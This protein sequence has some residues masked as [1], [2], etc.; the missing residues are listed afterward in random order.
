MHVRLLHP[1]CASKK[2]NARHSIAKTGALPA[3]P[4][5]AVRMIEPCGQAIEKWLDHILLKYF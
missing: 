1:I 2:W 4:A 3:V 5:Q